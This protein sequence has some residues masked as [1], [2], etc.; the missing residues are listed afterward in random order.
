MSSVR[1]IDCDNVSDYDELRIWQELLVYDETTE[2]Y[3]IR[4]VTDA[5]TEVVTPIDCTTKD[6]W[7]QLRILLEV[8]VVGDDGLLYLNIT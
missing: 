4:T 2:T 8:V 5:D 6:N 3:K 7:D 1:L